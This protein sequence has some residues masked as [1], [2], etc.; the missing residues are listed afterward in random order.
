MASVGTEALIT[1]AM[2]ALPWI[3]TGFVFRRFRMRVPMLASKAMEPIFARIGLKWRLLWLLLTSGF[4][5]LMVATAGGALYPP[6]V[7]PAAQLLCDGTVSLSSQE[8]SYKPGQQ[9][10]SH[11]IT[12]AGADGQT[13]VITFQSV[14]AAAA[15][16]GAAVFMLRLLWRLVRRRNDA[17]DF[18][19]AAGPRRY[20]P[21]G[22]ASGPGRADALQGLSDVLGADVM[23]QVQ[24]ALQSAD[25]RSVNVTV[26]GR[27]MPMTADIRQQLQ[28][29]LEKISV[30]A[31]NGKRIT[32]GNGLV[33]DPPT[34]DAASRLQQLQALRDQ[35]LITTAEFE[36]KRADIL[37][38]L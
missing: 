35:G 6:L 12:C 20:S 37:K 3:V 4:I 15:L 31:A 36:A 38:A 25:R 7:Q 1:L 18:G 8:Y 28:Y 34:Q 29:A 2:V 5:G 9:G 24:Q 17:V 13:A 19:S 16:Y 14:F 21:A 10:I 30:S 26:N 22:G 32:P 23:T 11:T 33:T 27:E